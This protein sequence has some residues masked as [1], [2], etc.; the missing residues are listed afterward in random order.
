MAA[1]GAMDHFLVCSAFSI[2]DCHVSHRYYDAENEKRNTNEKTVHST[3]KMETTALYA[4]STTT[5]YLRKVA[6]MSC[7][8]L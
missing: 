6:L 4:L 2:A 8:I 5:R 1:P 7:G 3:E